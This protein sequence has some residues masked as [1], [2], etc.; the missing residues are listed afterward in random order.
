MNGYRV[1]AFSLI[2]TTI[3]IA[4]AA[5]LILVLLPMAV[6]VQASTN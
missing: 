2:R 4:V 3:L 5:L 1:V 6:D